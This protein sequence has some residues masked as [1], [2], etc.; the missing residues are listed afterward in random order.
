MG[1][2]GPKS[3]EHPSAEKGYYLV[4]QAH[5]SGKQMEVPKLVR[6][7]VAAQMGLKP[8]PD[9]LIPER[10]RPYVEKLPQVDQPKSKEHMHAHPLQDETRSNILHPIGEFHENDSDLSEHL[11]ELA[12]SEEFRVGK[13]EERQIPWFDK[14]GLD[15][16][17]ET[18]I[19][20]KDGRHVLAD[21][22]K[23]KDLGGLYIIDNELGSYIFYAPKYNVVKTFD[24]RKIADVFAEQFATEKLKESVIQ[25]A[26]AFLQKAQLLSKSVIEAKYKSGNNIVEINGTE[27]NYTVKVNGEEILSTQDKG[28]ALHKYYQQVKKLSSQTSDDSDISLD[29]LGDKIVQL[30]REALSKL[31]S[32]GEHEDP[33]QKLLAKMEHL[34]KYEPQSGIIHGAQESDDVNQGVQE[35]GNKPSRLEPKNYKYIESDRQPGYK[36]SDIEQ[37]EPFFKERVYVHSEDEVPQGMQAQRGSRGGLY[38]DKDPQK[39]GPSVD[40]T[41]GDTGKNVQIKKEKISK[42]LAFKVGQKLGIDFSKIDLVQFHVGMNVELEHG[43]IDPETN[44]TDDNLFMT[45]KIAW[46]HIKEV[47]DYYTK[48]ENYVDSEYLHLLEGAKI[49]KEAGIT[50]FIP[51]EFAGNKEVEQ[52]YKVPAEYKNHEDKQDPIKIEKEKVYL[53][54]G[55]KAPEGRREQVG[56]RGG[57]FYDTDE[58]SSAS[59]KQEEKPNSDFSF[60]QDYE[61]APQFQKLCERV[62][63]HEFTED[64]QKIV[65]GAVD[66]VQKICG[67]SMTKIQYFGTLTRSMRALLLSDANQDKLGYQALLESCNSPDVP[68]FFM[69]KSRAFK[70]NI[71]LKTIDSLLP[72]IYARDKDPS[73]L[74]LKK[75][76]MRKCETEWFKKR[77]ANMEKKLGHRTGVANTFEGSI[78]HELGHAIQFNEKIIDFKEAMRLFDKYGLDPSVMIFMRMRGR[79]TPEDEKK[80]HLQIISKISEYANTNIQEFIAEAFVMK[81]DGTL[82]DIFKGM[83]KI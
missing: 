70:E 49:E 35:T 78:I 32:L 41:S 25:K 45:G 28:E 59:P 66:K 20:L 34:I 6:H 2:R 8:A 43:T 55:E 52:P 51:D 7:E 27:D 56:K 37:K 54:T 10:Q 24:R 40:S 68:S 53:R 15:A 47:A 76:V 26:T 36:Q 38:Y 48:L 80:D 44:V 82:P 69:R 62:D 50:P 58:A 73:Y 22:F 61:S 57:R 42:E 65:L 79:L 46:I 74:I 72:K 4:P 19:K 81:V 12:R 11:D 23:H 39:S 1:K 16:D 18:R 60:S 64:E 83:F 67:D 17:F 3:G 21:V 29:V 77:F 75:D 14:L 63:L 9:H 5:W 33:K 31:A 13:P 30:N 71:N